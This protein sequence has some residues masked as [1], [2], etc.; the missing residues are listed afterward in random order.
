MYKERCVC[1]MLVA[2]V[3]PDDLGVHSRKVEVDVV[4]LLIRVSLAMR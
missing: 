2:L 4:L 3:R 1:G